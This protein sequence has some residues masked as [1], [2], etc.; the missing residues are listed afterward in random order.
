MLTCFLYPWHVALQSKHLECHW[1]KFGLMPFQ[2]D[3]LRER[4]Q[5]FEDSIET[6]TSWDGFVTALDNK[7]MVLTPW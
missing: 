3:M 6:L 1:L 5:E 7:K 4:R 2:E